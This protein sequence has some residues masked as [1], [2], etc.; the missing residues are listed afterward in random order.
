MRAKSPSPRRG[1][2]G[3]S[4]HSLENGARR[5]RLPIARACGRGRRVV[6]AVLCPKQRPRCCRPP[7]SPFTPAHNPPHARVL[8]ACLVRALRIPKR[9]CSPSCD[10]LWTFCYCGVQHLLPSG[11]RAERP[12]ARQEPCRMK[13]SKSS[14]PGMTALKLLPLVRSSAHTLDVQWVSTACE[15]RALTLAG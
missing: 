11:E 1:S 13:S 12:K 2:C 7:R 4:Q 8:L 6:Q 9:A 3:Q 10:M 5:V 15:E 14:G